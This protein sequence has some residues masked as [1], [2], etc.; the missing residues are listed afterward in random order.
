MDPISQ[1]T[2]GGIFALAFS[3]KKKLFAASVVGIIAGL[4]P[5]LDILIRSVEDPLLR[6]E[7]HR[8]FTHSLIFIPIGALI[9]TIFTRLIFFKYLSFFENYFFAI[10]GYSTHGLLDTCTSYGT[11]LL[12]PFTNERYSW[13]NISVVDPFLT[14]PILI[15]LIFSIIFNKKIFTIISI[16]WIFIYLGFGFS[17]NYEATKSAIKLA[18]SRNHDFNKLTVKPSFGNLFLW[19]T[20]YLYENNYFVDAV[21]LISEPKFCY[22][23]TIPKLDIR[24]H[25]QNLDPKSKQFND[26]E[27]FNWF[28]QGYLGYDKKTEIITDVRYS[29]VPN[30]VDGLWGIQI[31]K[32]SNFKGHVK[33]VVNRS[34][35]KQRWSR[36]RNMLFGD[37]CRELLK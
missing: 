12:W 36:F 9:V 3:S 29:A 22:G 25:Y 32:D 30:E 18:K 31:N 15:L 16:L 24:K 5:D 10:L 20:V 35:F 28:S 11:Q 19:K 1:G 34:D 37:Q 4:S 23:T 21:N 7:Y 27:R 13:N 26:I 6:L 8:Q 2:F 17:Q 14:V 33:W